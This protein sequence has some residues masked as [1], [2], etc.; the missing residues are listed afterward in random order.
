MGSHGGCASQAKANG[1]DGASKVLGV[2]EHSDGASHGGCASQDKGRDGASKY[3]GLDDTSGGSSHGDVSSSGGC[4]SQDKGRDGASKA[5]GQAGRDG[6]SSSVGDAASQGQGQDRS[7]R[8]DAEPNSSLRE[9]QTDYGFQF[10]VQDASDG[11]EDSSH[12]DVSSTG[13]CASQDQGRDGAS[14]AQGQGR[15][16]ESSSNGDIASQGQ[17]KDQEGQGQGGEDSDSEDSLPPLSPLPPERGPNYGAPVQTDSL[18][19][20]RFSSLVLLLSKMIDLLLREQQGHEDSSPTRSQVAAALNAL[21]S[22]GESQHIV[23]RQ[24]GQRLA[25]PSGGEPQHR[26]HQPGSR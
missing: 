4:A 15:D 2:P 23:H 18:S 13:G 20:T 11:E 25:S 24:D 3:Q 5:Q 8:P 26:V 21:S 9:L 6:E 19:S 17:A 22:W 16:G 1:R 12:R 14:K 7:V 10:R